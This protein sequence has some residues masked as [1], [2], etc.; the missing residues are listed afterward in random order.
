MR[1]A[2]IPTPCRFASTKLSTKFFV[3]V[4]NRMLQSFAVITSALIL[5]S[6]APG[7]SAQTTHKKSTKHK[8]TPCRAGCKPDTTAPVVLTT[9]AGRWRESG[10]LGAGAES[11]QCRAEFLRK[12]FA[13]ATKHAADIW[14]ARAALALGYD[15]Y[16]KNRAPQALAWLTKAKNDTLLREYVLFWTAQTKRALKRNAEALADLNA[17][18]RDY[19][20]TAI[21]EQVVDALAVTATETGHPQ[22]AIDA[23]N[24]YSGTTSKPALLLDRAHA[25]Q[26]RAR[27]CAPRRTIKPSTIN[28]R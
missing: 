14:G 7:A 26:Q 12:T 11:S 27:Q 17:I 15:D 20:N 2:N 6:S 25:Y 10:I 19:P 8:S 24:E 5:L 18:R 1:S 22:D 9:S 23:L 16:Q 4:C 28:I 3:L 13:F 21:K